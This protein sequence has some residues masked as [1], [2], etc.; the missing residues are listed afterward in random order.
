MFSRVHTL[1]LTRLFKL[2][3][4][5]GK[6]G[7]L[8]CESVCACQI[9]PLVDKDVKVWALLVLRNDANRLRLGAVLQTVPE[10]GVECYMDN[11]RLC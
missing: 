2:S 1:T 3:F 7:V 10:P 11:E 5:P 6:K 9:R 8:M 4:A